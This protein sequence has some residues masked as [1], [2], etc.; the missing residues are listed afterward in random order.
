MRSFI[1]FADY[2]LTKDLELTDA[3]SQV[4]SAENVFAIWS[5]IG[6]EQ[7]AQEYLVSLVARQR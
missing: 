5:T 2:N 6:T 7:I 4:K 3:L 1:S